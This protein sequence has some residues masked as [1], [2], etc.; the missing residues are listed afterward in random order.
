M[1]WSCRAEA[2]NTMDRWV[3]AC[4]AQT[5]SQNAYEFKGRRYFWELSNTEH[6]D[7]AISGEIYVITEVVDKDTFYSHQVG[8]FFIEPDG[9]VSRA[10]SFLKEAGNA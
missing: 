1:G 4:R 3:A 6:A 10:P 9:H 2:G 5:G 8:T 7:G